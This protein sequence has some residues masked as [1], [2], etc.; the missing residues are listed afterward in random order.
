LQIQ[1]IPLDGARSLVDAETVFHGS[2]VVRDIA[3]DS[4]RGY[5]YWSTDGTLKSSL[6]DGRRPE[7]VHQVRSVR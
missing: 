1:R 7:N 2:E 6:L 5:I 3:L 4:V